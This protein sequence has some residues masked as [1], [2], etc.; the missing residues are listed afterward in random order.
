MTYYLTK[1]RTSSRNLYDIWSKDL[2]HS[3]YTLVGFIDCDK[4]Y[5]A[6]PDSKVHK[7][8]NVIFETDDLD[9]IYETVVMDVL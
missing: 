5:L 3:Y 8:N 9:A 4:M 2:N 6:I 7:I 1:L